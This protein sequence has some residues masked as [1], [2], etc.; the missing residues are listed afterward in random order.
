MAPVHKLL[1][2]V[3]EATISQHPETTYQRTF[4]T[5]LAPHIQKAVTAFRKAAGKGFTHAPQAQEILKQVAAR[6]EQYCRCCAK[7]PL[8]A[9]TCRCQ[10]RTA[11]PAVSQFKPLLNQSIRP[12][13]LWNGFPSK[14][15]LG[16]AETISC[17]GCTLSIEGKYV[18]RPA[19]L[20]MEDLSP[21]L[22]Q[23]RGTRIPIM[24][25]AITAADLSAGQPTVASIHAWV[26]VLGTKTR[27]KRLWITGSD[28]RR[29]CFLLKVRC[30]LLQRRSVPT[31]NPHMQQSLLNP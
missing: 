13:L 10:R 14:K 25:S 26:K 1:A 8:I 31:R 7:Q 24:T 6:V 29:Q 22:V 4:Q 16:C 11:C 19:D 5:D 30:G 23:M 18:H 20:R 9:C 12:G 15:Q 21:Q 3:S 2:F 27:P 28:G 17:A